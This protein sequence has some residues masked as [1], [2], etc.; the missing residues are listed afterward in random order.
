MSD[1]NNR[2]ECKN[3][4]DKIKSDDE[5]IIIERYNE[6]DWFDKVKKNKKSSRKKNKYHK[7]KKEKLD[8]KNSKI[9][10]DEKK[11]DEMKETLVQNVFINDNYFS[12]INFKKKMIEE[13]NNKQNENFIPLAKLKIL[14]KKANISNFNNNIPQ[15]YL[16]KN[17]LSNQ[18][19]LFNQRRFSNQLKKH[20]SI[21]NLHNYIINNKN[22]FDDDISVHKNNNESIL[23]SKVIYKNY[24]KFNNSNHQNIENYQDLSKKKM[25]NIFH[26]KL[27]R[28]NSLKQFRNYSF[29]KLNKN[30]N[31][32]YNN[33]FSYCELPYI[34][35]NKYSPFFNYE[36]YILKNNNNEYLGN[37]KRNIS[38]IYDIPKRTLQL[39][40]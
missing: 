33:E 12:K 14:N 13:E 37:Y 11:N 24:F 25:Y 39:K 29:Q 20:H 27:F 6:S 22:Y 19:Q 21:T 32:S 38:G 30:Q 36:D 7:T 28:A 17:N 10:V 16:N 8:T 3:G 18:N 34:Y 35:N 5:N 31:N 4:D 26:K 9:C 23:P 1:E 2:E 15:L 40:I